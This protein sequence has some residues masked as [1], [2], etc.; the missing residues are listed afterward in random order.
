M[1]WEE[2]IEK[3]KDTNIDLTNKFKSNNCTDITK[4][5]IQK[6]FE[7]FGITPDIVFVHAIDELIHNHIYNKIFKNVKNLNFNTNPLE[8]IVYKKVYENIEEI[9]KEFMLLFRTENEMIEFFK[10]EKK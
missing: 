1:T 7:N 8:A 5:K 4:K 6:E 2:L 10:K 9:K 3:L